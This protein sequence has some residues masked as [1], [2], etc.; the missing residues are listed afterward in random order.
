MLAQYSNEVQFNLS[1][2]QF[3]PVGVRSRVA[4]WARQELYKSIKLLLTVA[5]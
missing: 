3:L 2:R 1:R 4:S 5:R